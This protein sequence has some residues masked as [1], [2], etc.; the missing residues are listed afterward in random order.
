[1]K[2]AFTILIILITL[3]ILAAFGAYQIFF[4]IKHLNENTSSVLAESELKEKKR[5]TLLSLEREVLST[6]SQRN[7][8]D[9]FF[10]PDEGRVEFI[11][12]VENLAAENSLDIRINSL[13]SGKFEEDSPVEKFNF[14]I[15]LSGS[16]RN[17]YNFTITLESAP[18]QLMIDKFRI[19]KNGDSQSS[20]WTADLTFNVLK[21]KN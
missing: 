2:R 17:I 11:E 9:N 21:L 5:I 16:W 10:V 3:N 15:T 14:A 18:Y 1:M 7:K 20:E 12:L 8:L 13:L 6:E 19:T 4:K